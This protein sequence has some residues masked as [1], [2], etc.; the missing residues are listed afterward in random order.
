MEKFLKEADL[1]SASLFEGHTTAATDV[2]IEI[3]VIAQGLVMDA[4]VGGQLIAMLTLAY[5]SLNCFNHLSLL[6]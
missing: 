1:L 5:L 6:F 3:A 2:L 4:A